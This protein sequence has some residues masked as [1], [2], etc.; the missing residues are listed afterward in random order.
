MNKSK[1]QKCKGDTSYF[2]IPIKLKFETNSD[3]FLKPKASQDKSK[4]LEKKDDA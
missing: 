1:C 3:F 4:S 2:C